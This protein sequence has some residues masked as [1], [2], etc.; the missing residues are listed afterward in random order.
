MYSSDDAS[1][2]EKDAFFWSY[3]TPRHSLPATRTSQPR[4]TTPLYSYLSK[5][6]S[7][8]MVS[9]IVPT[10][11]GSL[12]ATALDAWRAQCEDAF[13]I[14]VSTKTEKTLPLNAVTKIRATGMQVPPLNPA[15]TAGL[16]L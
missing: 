8:S 4:H 7:D 6:F 5:L 14:H 13:A 11:P 12:T 2:N 15:F 16:G 3:P 1:S 9:K 10:F